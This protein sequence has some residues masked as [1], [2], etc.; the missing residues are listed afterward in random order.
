MCAA[1]SDVMLILREIAIEQD[2][3][4]YGIRIYPEA[5]NH[6]ITFW[7]HGEK[8]GPIRIPNA[9][10]K[11]CPKTKR[12]RAWMKRYLRQEIE[13]LEPPRKRLNLH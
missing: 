10:I 3:R 13:K 11:D 7:W 9:R 5:E 8:F 1:L 4:Y 2:Y 6:V 12:A